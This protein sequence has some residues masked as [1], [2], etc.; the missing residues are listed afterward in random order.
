LPILVTLIAPIHCYIA[1]ATDATLS[2]YP[3]PPSNM[4]TTTSRASTVSTTQTAFVTLSLGGSANTIE[5]LLPSKP[6]VHDPMDLKACCFDYL[7]NLLLKHA[8]L[9]SSAELIAT[10][11]H[12]L[13]STYNTTLEATATCSRLRS[14]FFHVSNLVGLGFC[15]CDVASITTPSTPTLTLGLSE[16]ITL[17]FASLSPLLPLLPVLPFWSALSNSALLCRKQLKPALPAVILISVCFPCSAHYPC[18]SNSSC[19]PGLL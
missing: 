10:S 4:S 8:S 16:F 11:G 5:L 9:Y 15:G 14:T 19:H 18:H 12:I 1:P 17:P 13:G 3:P 2:L 6:S 7:A